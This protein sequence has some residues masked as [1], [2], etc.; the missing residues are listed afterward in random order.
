MMAGTFLVFLSSLC[1]ARWKCQRTALVLFFI[2]LAMSL[3]I[4]ISH[5]TDSL[6]LQF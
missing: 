5:M 1:V 4:F 6:N 3:H 2:G